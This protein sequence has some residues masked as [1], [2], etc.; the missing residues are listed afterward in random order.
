MKKI[1]VF[2]LCILLLTGCG[3]KVQTEQNEAQVE[4]A[5]PQTSQEA[6]MIQITQE[7]EENFG[8]TWAKKSVVIPEL[9]KDY[10]VWFFAD[11]HIIIPDENASEE[12][13][14]YTVERMPVFETDLEADSAQIFSE[15]IEEANAKQ[16]DVILFGGDI[17]D[18]PSEANLAFLKEELDKLTVP[19]LFVMGN[20]DWTYPW[21]YMTAESAEQ[22]RPLLEE[23]IG[24][25]SYAQ[26]LEMEDI[27]FLAVDNSSNQVAQE[28]VEAIEEAYSVGKPIV[29]VQHVPFST[30]NLIARAKEDWNSPVTLG[31]QV[32]GGI[33]PNEAST[34]LFF[35]V[36]D[37][38]TNIRVVLAGHVHFPYEEQVSDS[39]VEMITDAA[40]KGNAVKLFLSGK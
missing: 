40:Y 28:A 21:E 23:I 6:E 18:F 30:E 24:G 2:I 32:H 14:N 39:T 25:S 37:D 5:E 35:K 20:H 33:A 7:T 4:T 19:Y 8:L 38:A 1:L 26:M 31:M 17:I 12:V 13:V 3:E 34:N 15:F 9:E 16:P 27:I 22:Y 10:E 29:L 36:F 11:S